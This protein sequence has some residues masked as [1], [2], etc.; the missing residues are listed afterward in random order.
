MKEVFAPNNKISICSKVK[1]II[2]ATLILVI[3]YSN[4]SS[5]KTNKDQALEQIVKQ[6]LVMNVIPVY[7]YV[8]VFPLLE[9]WSHDVAYQK[10][11][12]NFYISEFIPKDQALD[13]WTDMMTIT[14]YKKS[15]VSPKQYFSS[16]Y[17]M[18]QKICGEKGTAAQV[19]KEQDNFI[20]ALL[21]C[22]SPLDDKVGKPINLKHDQGEMTLYKIFKE[23]KSIYSIF[24]SWRGK[25]YD[26][27]DENDKNLPA[28]MSKVKEY[29]F[30]TKS[31]RI[32][33]KTNP[34]NECK[35]YVG[36]TKGVK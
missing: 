5:A 23:G 12:S 10:F 35:D 14:G 2:F 19:I 31:I 20:I 18:T 21:M 15:D 27:K 7:D 25:K 34:S 30:H 33:D 3:F 26:V 32:C 29:L 24:Y 9:N 28:P 16:L 8:V 1:R 6:K 17:V 36:L 11:D 4:H 13:K 22:G